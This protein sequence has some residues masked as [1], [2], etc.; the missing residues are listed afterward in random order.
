M[1]YI[2]YS[3]CVCGT[4][5]ACVSDY[6]HTQYVKLSSRVYLLIYN[7]VEFLKITIANDLD[8]FSLAL[9][10]VTSGRSRPSTWKMVVS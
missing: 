8:L 7:H 1:A 2:L 5:R 3:I 10:T 4:V 6:I 9:S